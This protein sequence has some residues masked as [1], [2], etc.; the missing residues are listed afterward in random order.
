MNSPGLRCLAAVG[1]EEEDVDGLGGRGRCR[2]VNSDA[3]PEELEL[4]LQHR[5]VAS[6]RMLDQGM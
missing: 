5:A 3:Q 4:V 6:W 1:V 2:V